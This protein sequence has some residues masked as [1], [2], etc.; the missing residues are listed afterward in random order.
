MSG[1]Y[2][3]VDN[4]IST[5]TSLAP[6]LKSGATNINYSMVCNMVVIIYQSKI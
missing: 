2:V 5:T 6:L 4:M 3:D 1:T